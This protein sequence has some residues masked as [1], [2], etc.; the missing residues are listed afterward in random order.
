M[1][2]WCGRNQLLLQVLS[3]IACSIFEQTARRYKIS[4][5][6]TS[7]TVLQ[8]RGNDDDLNAMDMG[9]ITSV[10]FQEEIVAH[11]KDLEV[12]KSLLSSYTQPIVL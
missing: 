1:S 5:S 11:E 9:E 2:L 6:G 12:V 7:T 10:R 3:A 4:E 8:E